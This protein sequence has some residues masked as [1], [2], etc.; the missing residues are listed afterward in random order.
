MSSCREE[1]KK[2]ELDSSQKNINYITALK[3][4]AEGFTDLLEYLMKL[5]P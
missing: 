4:A 2:Q 3:Q 5:F 1:A